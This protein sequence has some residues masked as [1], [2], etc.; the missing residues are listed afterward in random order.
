MSDQP[1][2]FDVEP[3]NLTRIDYKARRV[4]QAYTITCQWSHEKA[5]K[6]I[7]KDIHRWTTQFERRS[8]EWHSAPMGQ[9]PSFDGDILEPKYPQKEIA[10]L[11]RAIEILKREAPVSEA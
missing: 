3:E 5:I 9:K 6:A 8:A 11:E 2:L 7:Q 4:A 1:A 10:I